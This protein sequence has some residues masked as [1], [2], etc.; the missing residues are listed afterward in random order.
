MKDRC[1]SDGV[2]VDACSG[3]NTDLTFDSES[4]TSGGVLTALSSDGRFVVFTSATSFG[5]GLPRVFLLD[6]CMSS[7]DPVFPGCDPSEP[8]LDRISDS[9]GGG[10]PDGDKRLRGGVAERPVHRLPKQ[11]LRHPRIRPGHQWRQ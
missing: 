10:E 1:L 5:P 2:T 11:R 4:G 6:T 9:N 3:G 8:I 7:K